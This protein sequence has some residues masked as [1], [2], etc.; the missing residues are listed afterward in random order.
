MNKAH[1]MASYAINPWILTGKFGTTAMLAKQNSRKEIEQALTCY[2]I[3]L[4]NTF[5]D[6]SHVYDL[7][8]SVL[9][10]KLQRVNIFQFLVIGNR[11]CKYIFIAPIYYTISTHHS[12]KEWFSFICVV[13]DLKLEVSPPLFILWVFL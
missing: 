2:V 9:R 8:R 10:K 6:F 3:V 13:S 11:S 4:G 12:I 5:S 1:F 7:Y